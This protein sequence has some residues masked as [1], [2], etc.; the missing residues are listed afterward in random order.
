MNRAGVQNDKREIGWKAGQR[1]IDA[2]CVVFNVNV[3]VR[4]CAHEG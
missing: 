3:F 1:V 4:G 2:K